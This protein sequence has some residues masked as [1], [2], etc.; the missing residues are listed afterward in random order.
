MTQALTDLSGNVLPAH[1]TST[2]VQ[3]VL[4]VPPIR[5]V[6]NRAATEFFFSAFSYCPVNSTSAMTDP[7]NGALGLNGTMPTIPDRFRGR[8]DQF[9]VFCPDLVLATFPYLFWH[10]FLNQTPANVWGNMP[11]YPTNGAPTLTPFPAVLD[12]PPNTTLTM[13]AL[14]NDTVNQHLLSVFV[15]GWMWPIDT[16]EG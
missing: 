12:L 1:A 14:N 9:Q 6:P 15:H 5:N 3:R 8:I 11:V 7:I 13:T 16:A 2:Q 4:A 10:L